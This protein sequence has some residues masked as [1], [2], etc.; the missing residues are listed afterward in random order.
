MKR[1]LL[2]F[3]AIVLGCPVHAAE[4]KHYVL[5]AVFTVDTGVR[6]A[7][8]TKWVMFKGDTFPVMMFKEQQSKIVLQ[9]A[10]TSFITETANVKVIEEKDLTPGDLATY[11]TNVQHYLDSQAEKWKAEQLQAGQGKAEPPK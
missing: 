1:L 11:R 4:K 5:Y 9:M 2:L 10:G 7:E 6:L 8:G 3:L